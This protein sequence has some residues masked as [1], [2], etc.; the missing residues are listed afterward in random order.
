MVIRL[1]FPKEGNLGLNMSDAANLARAH[2]NTT[3]LLLSERER[4]EDYAWLYEAAEFRL[5]AGERVLEIGCGT[6]C[7]LLQFAKH[8]AIA[9]GVDISER[10][11]ELAR[12]RVVNSAEILRADGRNL[13]FSAESFDYVYSHGVIHHSDE[14]E[15]IA[16]EIVRV[17][18]PGGR[19]NVHVYAKWS[20][21]TLDYIR[22]YGRR[23]K[24]Q[25]E[26]S[27]DPVYIE[28]YTNA[29]LRKLFFPILIST[30]RFAIRRQLSAFQRWL[31]WFIICTG[32][33]PRI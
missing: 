32:T 30:R 18:R 28:L 4:Y 21:S 5:H 1:R 27:T 13:P 3:P 15:K 24:D 33:K 17:L 25:I 7:D 2:W 20:F 11:V 14:P 29:R 12:Q 23:W 26:N 19:F 22:L 10:H 31:G 9:T 16:S 8:S 6:G